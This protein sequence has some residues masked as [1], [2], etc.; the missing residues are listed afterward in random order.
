M[1]A[2]EIQEQL[3]GNSLSPEEKTLCDTYLKSSFERM[4]RCQKDQENLAEEAKNNTKELMRNTDLQ[5]EI[6]TDRD[7][8]W[9]TQI[10]K[11]ERIK[12]RVK[13]N[14]GHFNSAVTAITKA[15]DDRENELKSTIGSSKITSSERAAARSELEALKSLR[16]KYQSANATRLTNTL[17]D[18]GKNTVIEARRVTEA[19]VLLN[20][21][22]ER[23]ARQA[24]LI[25]AAKKTRDKLSDK[26]KQKLDD[27]LG[28]SLKLANDSLSLQH[29]VLELKPSWVLKDLFKKNFP[30][31]VFPKKVKFQT[32]EAKKGKDGKLTYELKTDPVTQKMFKYMSPK[33]TKLLN[34]VLVKDADAKGLLGGEVGMDEVSEGA[35]LRMLAIVEI[36]QDL[37]KSEQVT[38]LPDIDKYMKE[39][40][41]AG[42]GDTKE[43]KKLSKYA[44]S[45]Q[46]LLL[47]GEQRQA[48]QTM[49]QRDPESYSA[50]MRPWIKAANYIFGSSEDQK[51]LDKN[52]I[53]YKKI[54]KEALNSDIKCF[55]DALSNVKETDAPDKRP[56]PKV[57]V[58][59]A[60]K[61]QKKAELLDQRLAI[62][63][64]RVQNAMSLDNSPAG[65]N[66][67]NAE[68][69]E[70][71]SA[72]V[73]YDN[74]EQALER[75]STKM[76]DELG[77]LKIAQDEVLKEKHV[78]H[79]L[80][81][82]SPFQLWK[83]TSATELSHLGD[84]F[85]KEEEALKK[86]DR[87]LNA[88]STV[89]GEAVPKRSVKMVGD[90]IQQLSSKISD[91]ISD[92]KADQA[93]KPS[94]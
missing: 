30:G 14:L 6:R 56:D 91:A 72:H 3:F 76:Q 79:E 4:V 37:Y 52:Q 32:F 71:D 68:L 25:S 84:N 44:E 69:K 85:S 33:E 38:S 51:A 28:N 21:I 59:S 40:Y 86:I 5:N 46:A 61:L 13:N 73:D 26:D 48:K 78:L 18:D 58:K 47:T 67:L 70:M 62:I 7:A 53:A 49:G 77:D 93:A 75:F 34:T 55:S 80:V 57:L 81:D 23:D 43:Y 10:T 89:T 90:T 9:R 82:N 35:M 36:A 12:V 2:A 42:Y 1:G 88:D 94:A 17:R 66:A 74:F 8:A 24:S 27:E 50:I 64:N 20:T 45:R 31:E 22:D 29:G 83:G 19:R 92:A 54:L 15:L 41:D 16:T 63:E 65:L 11:A 87:A 60:E 39:L